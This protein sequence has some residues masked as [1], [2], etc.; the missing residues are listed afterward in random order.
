MPPLSASSSVNKVLS[1]FIP[2]SMNLFS[3][4]KFETSTATVLPNTFRSPLTVKYH[5]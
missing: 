3:T 2:N 1:D 4:L 5:Q